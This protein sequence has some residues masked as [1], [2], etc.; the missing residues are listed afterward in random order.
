MKRKNNLTA[1]RWELRN[2]VGHVSFRDHVTT[3]CSMSGVP[4]R[5]SACSCS[6]VHVDHDEEM[7]AMHVM[8]G[9]LDAELVRCSVPSKE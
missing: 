9:I 7:E 6:V 3:D 2:E 4:W 1:R 8:H 5:W